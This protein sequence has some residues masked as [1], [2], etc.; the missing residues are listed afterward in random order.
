MSK[1]DAYNDQLA[2]VVKVRKLL[3]AKITDGSAG[4]SGNTALL[5]EAFVKVC[6]AE[7]EAIKG[8]NPP[9]V[10]GY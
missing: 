2:D 10:A 1:Q 8:A 5:A 3:A 9:K 4:G 7:Q 6:Q